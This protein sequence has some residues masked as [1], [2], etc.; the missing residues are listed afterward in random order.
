MVDRL[1]QALPEENG[2]TTAGVLVVGSAITLQ[3]KISRDPERGRRVEVG[4]LDTDKVYRVKRDKVKKF[5][6]T[7]SGPPAFQ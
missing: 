5:S 4:F 2:D 7:S 3:R 1:E 6:A